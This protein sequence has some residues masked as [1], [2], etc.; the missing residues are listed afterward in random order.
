MGFLVGTSAF[1]GKAAAAVGAAVRP[2]LS[3]GRG[4]GSSDEQL[5]L[6][7]LEQ[8]SKTRKQRQWFRAGRRSRGSFHF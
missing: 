6:K 3:Q 7:A 5:L 8:H 1:E 4:W 2:C